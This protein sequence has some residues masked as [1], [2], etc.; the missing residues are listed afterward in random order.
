MRAIQDLKLVRCT[1]NS[2]AYA[3]SLNTTL[4]RKI[5]C[6]YDLKLILRIWEV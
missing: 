2:C 6:L 1:Y 4:S 5:G 3:F